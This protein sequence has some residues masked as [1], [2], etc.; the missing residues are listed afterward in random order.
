MANL[1]EI[2]EFDQK[3]HKS[4]EI[5]HRECSLC[6]V[7]TLQNIYIDWNEFIYNIYTTTQPYNYTKLHLFK[8]IRNSGLTGRM[9]ELSLPLILIADMIDEEVVD[10]VINS[11][12]KISIEKS[13]ES[14]LE[15][16]DILLMDM[17]AQEP[18]PTYFQSIKAIAQKFKEFIQSNEEWINEKWVGKALK[19]MSLTTNRR[20]TNRGIEVLLDVK[21]AQEKVKYFKSEET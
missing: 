2:W 9:L 20:R 14:F 7:V 5:L 21:K 11:L 16:K 19:R 13:Q 6:S 12:S 4:L 10:Q 3:L 18:F 17:V 15:N 1:L 8:K